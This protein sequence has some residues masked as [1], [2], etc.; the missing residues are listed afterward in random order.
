VPRKKTTTDSRRL[1]KAERREQL[2]ETALAIVRERGTDALTLA[3]LAEEAGVTKPIA[4]EHFRTRAG[5][6]IALYQQIDDQQIV[7]L[8]HALE[9]TPARLADVARVLSESYIACYREHGVEW[10]ALSSALHGDEEMDAFQRKLFDRYVSVYRDAVSPHVRLNKR[11][12]GLRCVCIVGA[13]DAIARDMVQERVSEA[14]TVATLTSL[15][16]SWLGKS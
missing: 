4:Y 10:L 8:R 9:R 13:A 15:I 16:V 2:L 5:L 3:V 7:A 14:S 6:L 1:T 12:L 11:E